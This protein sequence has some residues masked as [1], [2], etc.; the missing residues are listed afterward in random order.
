ME[1]TP[2][3]VHVYHPTWL[4]YI[5]L[6]L[7]AVFFRFSRVLSVRNLDLI[8]ILALSTTLVVTGAASRKT[9]DQ[10]AAAETTETAD[11][12]A[13]D[14]DADVEQ[15]E[16]AAPWKWGSMAVFGLSILLILRLTF[17]ESLTRRPRLEQNLNQAGLTFLFFPAFSILMIGVIVND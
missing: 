8:L 3:F 13:S 2:F 7:V 5:S 15:E 14:T 11:A 16:S 1:Q 10:T 17:D 12:A 6:L 9:D 4:L